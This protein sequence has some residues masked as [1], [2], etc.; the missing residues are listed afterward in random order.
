[1]RH[2]RVITTLTAND[3]HGSH[4]AKSE[5]SMDDDDVVALIKEYAAPN[6][7][8]DDDGDDKIATVTRIDLA[9]LQRD[10]KLIKDRC[11]RLER[12]IQDEIKMLTDALNGTQETREQVKRRISRLTGALKYPGV[13]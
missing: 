12:A 13:L 3:T 11:A 8:S 5:S 6:F 2:N 1:M 9:F 7:G 4:V 10:L